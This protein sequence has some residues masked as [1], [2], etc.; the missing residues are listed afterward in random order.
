MLLSLTA[1]RSSR[2]WATF[3][4]R[5]VFNVAEPRSMRL[6]EREK[7][8]SAAAKARPTS[9]AEKGKPA[10]RVAGFPRFHSGGARPVA[11]PFRGACLC[12]EA[13]LCS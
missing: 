10:F 11:A 6:G 9:F 4:L 7:R 3:R 5:G 1:L 13:C 12:S 2:K 8:H